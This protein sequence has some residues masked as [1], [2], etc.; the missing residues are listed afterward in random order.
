MTKTSQEPYV[1]P[2][3]H[4]RP[5]ERFNPLAPDF[6]RAPQAS[7]LAAQAEQPVFFS[8]VLNMWVVTRHDDLKAVLQDTDTFRS[9]G[10]FYAPATV[11]PAALEVL[12]GLD[13]PVFRYSLVN[14][15]P[16][17]HTRFRRNFQRAFT[18]RQVA[19]LEPQIRAL[20]HDL[21]AE[22]R[23][24]KRAEVVKTL[25]DRLPLLTICRLMGID[26]RDA[27]QIKRWSTDFIRL[28][29]PGSSVEEQRAIGQ[30]V[31]DYYMFMRR[32]VE[33]Y[34]A[35]A[36]DNLI[37]GVI[38]ARQSDPEPLDDQEI[39]SLCVGMVLAGHETTAAWLGNALQ[40]LLNERSRWEYLCQH[41]GRIT[42][43][44]DELMRH[45]GPAIGLFRRT[46]R[47]VV[48]R[49][50]GIPGGATV[51][52]PYLG[53]N[54]DPAQFPEPEQL[55]LER[56]NAHSHLGFGHGSHYCIGAPLARLEVRL[57]LEELTRHHPSLRLAP[58][59]A[60]RPVQNFMLR[61]NEE[62]I[63]LID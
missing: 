1:C 18:P 19:L 2:I 20:I 27:P 61:A 45:A 5:Q 16:P 9:E 44:L 40:S 14:T 58:D 29:I 15:D 46:S 11:S 39:A 31:L 60:V 57:A 21:L 13:H 41:P 62:M 24:N 10:A 35:E 37:H 63:L 34:T 49:G 25:C 26:D 51:F 48:V 22:L 3:A 7:F 54:H 28:Q 56:D 36:A 23:Q 8:P 55:R 17:A 4:S 32:L 47:D 59:Q 38:I 30:S 52:V 53:A 6:H 43:A 50:V 33:R 42:L 12:G